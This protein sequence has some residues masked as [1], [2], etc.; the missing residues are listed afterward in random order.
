MET[1]QLLCIIMPLVGFIIGWF[2]NYIAI[3]LLFVPHKKIAGF[4]GLIPSRKEQIA[5][6]IAEVSLK[7][8]P[9]TFEKVAK[10]PLIGNRLLEIFKKAVARRIKETNDK[11]IEK[12]VL[13]VAKKEFLFIEIIGGILGDF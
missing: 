5:K 11:E 12:T 6:N 3:K 2:T 1:N 13:K 8:M 4:Q 10:T 7:I 9:K